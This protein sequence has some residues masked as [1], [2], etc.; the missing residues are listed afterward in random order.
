MK[1]VPTYRL[2]LLAGCVLLPSTLLVAVVAP[3]R[4]ATILLA[5]GLF[6]VAIAV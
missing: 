4:I 6:V 2:L 5:A 1:I 3:M